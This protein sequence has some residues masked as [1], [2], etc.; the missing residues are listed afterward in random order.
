MAHKKNCQC[1]PCCYRRGEDKGQAPRLSIRLNPEIRDYL[2]QHEDGARGVIERLVGEEMRAGSSSKQLAL[3]EAKRRS[4]GPKA[5]ELQVSDKSKGIEKAV[6]APS[7]LEI[8]AARFTHTLA[9]SRKIHELLRP[10]GLDGTNGRWA[11]QKLRLGYCSRMTSRTEADK[12]ELKKLGMLGPDGRDCLAGCL[13]VPYCRSN[14]QL[15][16]FC[17]VRIRPGKKEREVITGVGSGLLLTGLDEDLVLV[18]GVREAL[19]CFGVGVGAV[20]AL[21][22]LTPGWFPE[23]WSAGVRTVKLAVS[24]PERAERAAF[25]LT[26]LG[27]ECFW[28]PVDTDV[29]SRVLMFGHSATIEGILERGLIKLPAPRGKAKKRAR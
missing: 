25:E 6:A 7:V 21:D 20:Q 3:A 13:T 14:E 23:F 2:L 18:D 17:G 4:E 19:T 27:M 28:A 16:G 11:A 22:L 5:S 24:D 1:P 8:W 12:K 15:V 29:E 26:R 9:R 10:V